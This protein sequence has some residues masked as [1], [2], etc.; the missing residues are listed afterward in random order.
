MTGFDITGSVIEATKGG[1]GEGIAG[2]HFLLYAVGDK[3]RSYQCTN[4]VKV[5]LDKLGR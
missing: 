2:V 4:D 5:P 1:S 3:T